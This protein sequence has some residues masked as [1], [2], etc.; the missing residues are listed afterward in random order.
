[1]DIGISTPK[2][3]LVHAVIGFAE[4]RSA[5]TRTPR[6]T[7]LFPCKRSVEGSGQEVQQKPHLPSCSSLSDSDGPAS[8]WRQLNNKAGSPICGGEEIPARRGPHE[9]LHC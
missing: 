5:A 9:I 8:G 7:T 6:T 4:R 1:M 2:D 3:S